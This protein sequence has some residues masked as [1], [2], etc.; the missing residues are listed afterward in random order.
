MP[1]DTTAQDSVLPSSPFPPGVVADSSLSADPLGDLIKAK[2]SSQN[3]QYVDSLKANSDLQAEVAYKAEDSIVFDVENGMLFLY[4]ESDLT[5]EEIGLK[6]ERIVVEIDNQTLR[7]AGVEDSTGKKSGKP[8]FTES[9]TTYDAEDISYNFNSQKGRVTNGKTVQGDGFI[10]ADVAKYQDD[11]TFHGKDGKYTTCS[12][13]HPHYYIQSRK[14]KMIPDG[15]QLIS[16]PL[17][18]VIGDLP[19]PIVVPFGFI[20]NFQQ[21]PNTK[22]MLKPRWGESPERGFFLQNLGYFLPINEYFALQVD[23]DIFTRGGWRLGGTL[24][25]NVRYR[26]SGQFRFQYGVQRFNERTDF[27]FRRTAAWNLTWSHRQPINPNT[28]ITASVNISSSSS[29]QRQIEND[30]NSLFTNNL[31]SSVNFQ[32]KFANTPFSMNMSL[33]HQQDLNRGTMSMSLPEMSVNMN[34]QTPFKN[35]RS[36]KLNFLRTL[37]INYN[38]QARNRVSNIPDS[39]LGPVLFRPDELVRFRVIEGADTSFIDRRAGS[40][41]ENGMQHTASTSTTIKVLDYINISPSFNYKE[42]WYLNQLERRWDDAAEEIIDETIPGFTRGFDFSS[43]VSAS[44]NFFGIYEF[45]NSKREI[46]F[47]QRFTPTV[48]YNIKPD[49]ADPRYGFYRYVQS[50]ANGDSLRYS[51]FD[52]GIYR[53]PTAGESQAI[54]FSMSSVIE[55]RYRTLESF[56][57]DFDSKQDKYNRI[58]VLDNLSMSSSYNFAADSFNLAPVSLR[59]RTNLLN[60]KI[61]LNAS[62]TFDPYFLQET[63]NGTGVRVNRFQV[64]ETGQLAR[65]TRAQLTLSTTLKS[66]KR[67]GKGDVATVAPEDQQEY[68]DV[69]NQYYQ[70][71]DFN[72]PW[73]VQIRYNLSYSKTTLDDPRITSTINLNGG[74]NF[75]PKWKITINTGFDFEQKKATTTSVAINRDLHCWDMALRWVPFGIRRSYTFSLNVRSSLLQQLR[76]S[77]NAFWQ[78]QFR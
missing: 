6:A 31:N 25:Y 1:A 13:D 66:K 40:F 41:Y 12:H 24:Q 29:F 34:R 10:L 56:E 8:K 58:R 16:G 2:D 42:F 38:M 60:N 27:D 23:G 68:L 48:S 21:T 71:V 75:T 20:P 77:K 28:S 72:I 51:I 50:N 62:T 57:E 18:L 47:R 30:L 76:I 69:L 14:L 55:M 3:Q 59:A 43:A 53:G 37:G 67:T 45:P 35:I 15:N 5:Y 73:N 7:A 39:L 49:F 11:G 9:G 63:E 65:L 70:Y 32:K 61:N 36:R 19:I 22:G 54:S 17:N 52:D 78:D 74:F 4:H 26:F 44:T 33:R 64:S 46:A